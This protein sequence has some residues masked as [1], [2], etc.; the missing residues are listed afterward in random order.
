VTE[1][2]VATVRERRDTRDAEYWVTRQ[3]HRESHEHVITH[4]SS[5]QFNPVQRT[6]PLPPECS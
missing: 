5:A 4:S 2:M 3:Q 1:L 6:M